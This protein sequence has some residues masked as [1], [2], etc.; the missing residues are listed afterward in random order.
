MATYEIGFKP[1]VDPTDSS[2]AITRTFS[3]VQV[4]L[5]SYGSSISSR[6][7]VSAGQKITGAYYYIRA[8][9]NGV[10]GTVTAGAYVTDS[11]TNAAG[12]RIS[13]WS[14]GTSSSTPGWN[15][16][17]L[18]VD[19]NSYA[20]QY[21]KPA[22]GY[23]VNNRPYYVTGTSG[24]GVYVASDLPN[25]YGSPTN[26]T[27]IHAM[28]LVIEDVAVPTITDVN[29]DETV[30]VGSSGNVAAVS[31]YAS[32]PTSVTVGGKACAGV[33]Y[34]AGNV[35][36]TMP[37][38]TDGQ[39][40]PET[41]ED[42]DLVVSNATPETD[43]ITVRLA[44]PAD[45]ASIP[46]SSPVTNDNTYAGAFVSTVTGDRWIFPKE[47]PEGLEDV[48]G[49]YG[50]NIE[51]DTKIITTSPGTRVVWK[52]TAADSTMTLINLTINDAGEIVSNNITARQITGTSIT[53][54]GI[55]A[56]T[57]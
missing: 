45:H 55:T 2:A 19:L 49:N 47:L 17:A 38:Y 21:I 24:H 14:H 12:A 9:T 27:Q 23:S 53:G 22:G 16:V 41:D 26:T 37:G 34:N 32:S 7:L 43:T 50:F 39:T 1:T 46:I 15:Y 29:G 10:A 56:S 52:W 48:P 3:H 28:Y 4:D 42:H 36:F 40:Y 54:S 57:L 51:A 8:S 18:D 20:G 33:S 6:H 11:G 30:A 25:P 13:T 31:N 35:T 5:S 44:S